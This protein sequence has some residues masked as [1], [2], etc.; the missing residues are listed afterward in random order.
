[1]PTKCECM[2][3]PKAKAKKPAIKGKKKTAAKTVSK[4]NKGCMV[5][6][7]IVINNS[8]C[9][10]S[11]KSARRTVKRKKTTKRV[12]QPKT[13]IIEEIKAVEIV[14]A[15]PRKKRSYPSPS[16]LVEYSAS[17]YRES[18]RNKK[19]KKVPKKTPQR[20][21]KTLGV[22]EPV[23][24]PK[25]SSTPVSAPPLIEVV[26]YEEPYRGKR[27]ERREKSE[28]ILID[29]PRSSSK[30]VKVINVDKEPRKSLRESYRE[31]KEDRLARRTEK[32][33]RRDETALVESVPTYYVEES[34]K[35]LPSSSKGKSEVIMIEAPKDS[36]IALEDCEKY[37]GF[38]KERCKKRNRKKVTV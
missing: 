25:R 36:E 28:P 17:D 7:I 10:D 34:P 16:P 15:K 19:P 29:S 21:K 6:N 22:S 27:I 9:C 12:I 33:G 18:P 37:S 31:Y 24:T 30:A 3:T 5:K 4:T 23:R 2:K 32:V 20:T 1:M 13:P 14:K 35:A 38:A 26:D 11:K 8:S